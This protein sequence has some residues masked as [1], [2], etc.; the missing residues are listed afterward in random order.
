MKLSLHTLGM[1]W[2]AVA[3]PIDVV[4]AAIISA[5]VLLTK[6]D[7][8]SAIG[9][10][11]LACVAPVWGAALY[12]VFGINRVERRARKLRRGR[13]HNERETRAPASDIPEHFRP[14]ERATRRITSRTASA[15]N[16]FAMLE[17]GDAAYPAMLAAIA[18]ARTSVALSSY[19]MRAD[20]AGEPFIAALA[21]AHARGVQVRV[22]VDGI[23][24]GYFSSP[25]YRALCQ[26]GVP[27]ARFLHSPLPWR[28]PFLNLRTHKKIL[29]VDGCIGFTGGMNI[30]HQNQ[31]AQHPPDPVRDTHFRIDG[32]VV[33]QLAEAFARDW[34]FITDEDLDGD[35]WFPGVQEVGSKQDKPPVARVVTSG[36]DEDIEKIEFVMLEAIGCARR[37]IRLM[38]PYFL[39]SERLITALAMASIRGTE[40]DVVVPQ[41]SDHMLVDWSLFAHVGP[42]LKDGV[43]IWRNPPPFEH[44]KLLVV[45][46]GWCMIGSANWDMRSLRLNFE[47]NVEVYDPDLA[48]ELEAI[49]AA[50]MHTR[51]TDRE[52]TSQPLPIRLR[53]AAT[54]LL[55]PYL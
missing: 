27:A 33:E 6:R 42:L 21:A 50:R 14:M 26:Q 24:S 32:P 5:H 11:G 13:R 23:G 55:V 10:I 28:M 2:N 46:S 20:K 51:L 34:S 22:L 54:R 41:K 47:L 38:T 49:M 7:I 35:A 40:V 48:A 16:S 17:N 1:A 18:A 30:A 25:A 9:W 45:D 43:R 12:F 19:I 4:I 15:G 39:P 52:L 3:T 36:P 29:V 44:T 8:G 37:R 31:V 53:D